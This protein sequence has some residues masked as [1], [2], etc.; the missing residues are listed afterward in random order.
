MKI[1]PCGSTV[2]EILR[3]PPKSL[4][5][6]VS[7]RVFNECFC[8]LSRKM[9]TYLVACTKVCISEHQIVRQARVSDCKMLNRRYIML[10]LV[11][12]AKMQG[13]IN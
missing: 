7:W 6:G 10:S 12:N 5:R 1:G 4:R 13:E 2:E 3:G 9:R 8:S 11:F